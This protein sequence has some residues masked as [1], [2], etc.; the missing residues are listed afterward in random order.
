VLS[1]SCRHQLEQ[2]AAEL[3]KE[4]TRLKAA[5]EQEVLLMENSGEPS[6]A[7][8]SLPTA[9]AIMACACRPMPRGCQ[10]ALARGACCGAC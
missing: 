9:D 3:A 10:R 6:S 5:A 4:V 1:L 8:R 7:G 2:Q